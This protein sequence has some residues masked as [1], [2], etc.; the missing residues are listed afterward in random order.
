MTM[1]VI[2]GTDIFSHKAAASR[3]A[4]VA[5][6]NEGQLDGVIL[7]PDTGG[8]GLNIIGANHV[9]FLSSMYSIDYENQCTGQFRH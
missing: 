7:T 4:T 6:L 3:Q 5:K 8:V 9:L 2:C 1:G